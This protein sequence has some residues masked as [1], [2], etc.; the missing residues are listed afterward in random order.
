MT[1]QERLACD[2][3]L[4]AAPEQQSALQQVIVDVEREQRS[5]RLTHGKSL[6]W[7]VLGQNQLPCK[8]CMT[9]EGESKHTGLLTLGLAAS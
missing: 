1:H 2:D 7:K 3:A 5:N 8:S 9:P 4:A 6:R